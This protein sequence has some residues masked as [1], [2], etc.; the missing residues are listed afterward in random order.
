M[1]VD[2]ALERFVRTALGARIAP[3]ASVA[4]IPD[5]LH[6]S[7]YAQTTSPWTIAVDGVDVPMHAEVALWRISAMGAVLDTDQPRTFRRPPGARWAATRE[8]D[9]EVISAL[10]DDVRHRLLDAMT[11]IIDGLD[12]AA[13]LDLVGV[14]P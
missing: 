7:V 3:C 11:L 6:G 9:R 12:P 14:S 10:P 8:V 2:L 1:M 5:D 4:L 13:A